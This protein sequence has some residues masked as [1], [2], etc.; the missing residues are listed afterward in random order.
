MHSGK[1]LR[2]RRLFANGRA[3]VVPLNHGVED[4]IGLVRMLARQGIDGV[5]LAP[6]I[7]ERVQEDLGAL[8]VI[9]RLN[10]ASA[11]MQQLS[12][13]QGALELGAEAALFKA[14]AHDIGDLERLGIAMGQARRL[15]MPVIV[16][17][18]GEDLC[19][20]VSIAG[21][22]GADAIQIQEPGD[23][24]DL[25]PVVRTAGRPILVSMSARGSA[26]DLLRVA[27]RNLEAGVQGI[28]I[29]PAEEAVLVALASMV[30]QGVSMEEALK[31]AQAGTGDAS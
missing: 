31:M 3:F 12:T 8:A 20:M 6:G 19:S 11:R 7:L 28:V 15:G 29:E 2:L 5:T 1:F 18:T 14:D 22:Y 17:I 4:L 13:V 24:A 25:R 9:L 27:Q 16:E 23:A 30:H 21:E 26:A 10:G